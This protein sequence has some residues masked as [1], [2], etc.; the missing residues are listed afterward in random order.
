MLSRK[1]FRLVLPALVASCG[2][3]LLGCSGESPQ[4]GSDPG[5]STGQGG[6]LE[7]S[8]GERSTSV[9][10]AVT[11][12]G[13][14]SAGGTGA[15]GTGSGTG[16]GLGTGGEG[17]GVPTTDLPPA[18]PCP[19]GSV[20]EMVSSGSYSAWPGT[21]FSSVLPTENGENHDPKPLQVKVTN[22]SG[23]SVIGCEVRFESE[24][25]NG[26]GFAAEPTTDAQGELYGYWIAGEPGENVISAVILLQGGGESRVDFSG[27]VV[28]TT[29][30]TD[31]VHINY[32]VDAA[33]TEFKIQITPVT[34]APATYY[35]ALNF[36]D[37]YAGIQFDGDRTLVLFSVWDAGGEDATIDDAGDC[38]ATVGF[39]GEGTG[40][41]CRF[42]FPPSEHGSVSGLPDDYMLE[43]GNTYELHLVTGDA[44][45]G[46]T[47]NTITFT[48]VT[49]GFGPISL[50]TQ[51][52]GTNFTGG[53]Y[54]SGFV[55]EWTPHGSCL[56]ATRAVYYHFIAYKVG[57]AA[58]QD[59]LTANFSPNYVNT[60]NEICANYLGQAFDGKFFVSSGGSEFVGRPY[61]PGDPKFPKPQATMTLP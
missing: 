20:V 8:G 11:T 44:G 49:R 54:A 29:S 3:L 41:S 39:G 60:N 33:Y 26:W 46:R 58:W 13:S 14:G 25:G 42:V 19:A 48:D 18:A 27:K 10:G 1:S 9:G 53:G 57:A 7:G 22:G 55:E 15:G 51:S 38:N 47:E 6:S 35:S 30:R 2:P 24:D 45:A 50:G 28:N 23:A 31:S 56:S 37:S 17:G 32:D 59:V 5:D 36:R 43:V 4:G 40:T 52:T 21:L 61:V 16:G 12:G 34:Q